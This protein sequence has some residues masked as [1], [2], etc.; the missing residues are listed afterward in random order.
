MADFAILIDIARLTLSN[1]LKTFAASPSYQVASAVL[2]ISAI[3]TW[4]SLPL[5]RRF[6]IRINDRRPGVQSY[7]PKE[8][9]EYINSVKRSGNAATT[10][11]AVVTFAIYEGFAISLFIGVFMQGIVLRDSSAAAYTAFFVFLISTFFALVVA[12]VAWFSTY[13]LWMW[14]PW[15]LDRKR[16]GWNSRRNMP[17]VLD[18]WRGWEIEDK[19]KL[20]TRVAFP[21]HQKSPMCW[22]ELNSRYIERS[23]WNALI[24]LRIPHIYQQWI[25]TPSN[26]YIDFTLLNP[27]T[28]EPVLG[29]ETDEWHHFVDERLQ[30]KLCDECFCKPFFMKNAPSEDFARELEIMNVHI[31]RIADQLPIHRIPNAYW[32]RV[33]TPN[34]M[35]YLEE[36]KDRLEKVEEILQPP[37]K[38][39]ECQSL[40]EEIKK[41]L[42]TIKER[43]AKI[44]NRLEKIKVWLEENQQQMEDAKEQLAKNRQRLDEIKRRLKEIEEG[45]QLLEKPKDNRQW[46]KEILPRHLQTL[47]E[48]KDNQHRLLDAALRERDWIIKE[49]RKRTMQRWLPRL[50]RRQ[51]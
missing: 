38:T 25:Q 12:A 9:T 16:D 21:S 22:G 27:E 13:I 10:F 51:Q 45:L 7:L 6:R 46:L 34:D 39:E 42:K 43:L 4:L 40:L 48:I 19:I 44:K 1:W 14:T 2:A 31:P 36:I 5:L 3:I 28:G 17:N 49:K 47:K 32:F 11:W 30:G 26:R 15:Y 41:K 18:G 24:E 33:F 8:V 37:E 20:E 50:L 23:F 35:K 29:I